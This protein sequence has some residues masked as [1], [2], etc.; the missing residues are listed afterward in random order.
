MLEN[1]YDGANMVFVVGCPRSGTTWLQRLLS[2][3]PG[4]RTGQESDIFD[5]YI[6]PQLRHWRRDLEASTS[7]RSGVGL[8]CYLREDEFMTLLRQY[9]LQLLRP[10]VGTLAPGQVFVEKTPS[11]ALYLPEIMELLPKCKVVGV[12]RDCRDVCASLLAAGRSWGSYW[13]PK[14]GRSAAEMWV[15]HQQAMSHAKA[16]AETGR[17]REV[18]YEDLVGDT[19]AALEQLVNGFLDLGCGG[20]AIEEAVTRCLPGSGDLPE[21]HVGGEW[22]A[23]TEARSVK[24]PVGFVRKARSGSWKKDLSCREKVGIWRMARREMAKSGYPWPLPW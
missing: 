2:C 5:Q 21:L 18:R 6:G 20:E 4:V 7:G 17:Y 16:E 3:C 10:L 12:V 19:P 14:T 15:H 11:H 24:E 23:R 22:A 13:A 1:D 9:M 8:G